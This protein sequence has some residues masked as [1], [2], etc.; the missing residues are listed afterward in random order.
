MDEQAYV[1]LLTYAVMLM[2]IDLFVLFGSTRIN[3][4]KD[5]LNG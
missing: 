1:S 4:I 3:T 5:K 2:Y